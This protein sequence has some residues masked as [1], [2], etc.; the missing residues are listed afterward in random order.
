[1]LG[2]GEKD[3]FIGISF[4]RYSKRTARVMEFASSRGASCI[5]ITDSEASPLAGLA[6]CTLLCVSNM[7][8]FAD[9]LVAPLSVINALIVALSREKQEAIKNG[10][11]ELESIWMQYDVYN[12]E[13][14]AAGHRTGAGL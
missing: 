10:L 4:P 14:P 12:S 8:S 13:E 2:V 6:T 3:V 5:A 9:S 1:M 7:I 11:T